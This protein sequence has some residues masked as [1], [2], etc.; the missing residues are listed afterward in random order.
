MPDIKDTVNVPLLY[1]QRDWLLKLPECPEAD[2]LIDL[3]E[4]MLDDLEKKGVTVMY[5]SKNDDQ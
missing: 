4:N 2:G 5:R 1:A 3:L